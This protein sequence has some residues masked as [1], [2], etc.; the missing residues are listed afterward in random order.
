[1]SYI[2]PVPSAVP[3]LSKVHQ[4]VTVAVNLI[5]QHLADIILK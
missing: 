4:T 5:K 3:K 2:R 1:M